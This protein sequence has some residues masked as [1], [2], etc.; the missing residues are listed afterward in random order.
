MMIFSVLPPAPSPTEQ[1]AK[2]SLKGIAHSK[3]YMSYLDLRFVRRLT[4]YE[5]AKVL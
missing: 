2:P 1:N 3:M 5:N 4:F